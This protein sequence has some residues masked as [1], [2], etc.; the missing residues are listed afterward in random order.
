M[1]ARMEDDHPDEKNEKKFKNL[2]SSQVKGLVLK[3][4]KVFNQAAKHPLHRK[5]TI[6]TYQKESLENLN[7]SCWKNIRFFCT[8]SVTLNG[9]HWNI[10]NTKKSQNQLYCLIKTVVQVKYNYFY[11]YSFLL[12][13]KKNKLQVIEAIVLQQG[14]Q[15]LTLA[16]FFP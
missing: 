6:R 2:Q 3:W 11:L 4:V 7:L 8:F 14:S 5:T 1:T 10:T 16:S 12:N 9:L 15:P 13:A